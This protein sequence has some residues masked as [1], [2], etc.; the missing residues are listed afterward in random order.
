MTYSGISKTT[1]A[2]QPA[3]PQANR[4]LYG[5]MAGGVVVALIA[6][7]SIKL[8]QGDRPSPSAETEA[9]PM[10]E[11]G[12]PPEAT[13]GTPFLQSSP[14][15]RLADPGLLQSTSPQA[16]IETI[17]AGRVDPFAPL[18]VTSGVPVK[19]N[20]EAVP[21][22]PAAVVAA[23]PL[24]VVP[25]TATQSL[26][27]LPQ[28]VPLP[29][30]PSPYVPG[31]TFQNG[32]DVAVAPTV[33]PVLQSLVEQVTVSGVVQVGNQVSAIVTEPGSRVGRRVSQGDVVAGGRIR[34]KAIDVSGPEPVVVLS[35]DGRDYPRTVGS[36]ALVS[37]R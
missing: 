29:S 27:P 5:L 21:V 6:G 36:A 22:P 33:D 20:P 1:V 19:P 2:S 34:V 23:S 30:L 28:V 4:R 24:P 3:Q 15:L 13:F 16:R 32:Q 12:A 9:S 8:L 35:Y 31:S 37:T 14:A 7:A 11:A 10:V 17:A 18:V 25:V 26:P